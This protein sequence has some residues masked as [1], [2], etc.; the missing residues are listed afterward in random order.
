LKIKYKEIVLKPCI[1]Y[2]LTLNNSYYF[3]CFKILYNK[4]IKPILIDIS[5]TL[6]TGK[7][8]K[9]KF[10]K[11]ITKPLNILSKPLPIVPPRI[12][13]YDNKSDKYKVFFL[14][15]K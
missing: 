9:L 7:F 4:K 2:T 3:L 5:A 8:I 15:I 14:N 10:I 11:S 12:K 1:L 6:N 13:V